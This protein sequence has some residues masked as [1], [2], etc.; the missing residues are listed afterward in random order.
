M[1]KFLDI[2]RT[3]DEWKELVKGLQDS[4][5]NVVYNCLVLISDGYFENINRRDI[6]NKV[7]VNIHYIDYIIDCYSEL[8]NNPHESFQDYYEKL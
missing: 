6:A 1:S 7:N 5:D 4:M 8:E 2:A 3:E